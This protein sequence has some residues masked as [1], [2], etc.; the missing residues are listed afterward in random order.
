MLALS[1]SLVQTE[2]VDD[3]LKDITRFEAIADRS[4]GEI[5]PYLRNLLFKIVVET[6]RKH[7]RRPATDQVRYI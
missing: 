4:G 5:A 6:L 3:Q 2:H 7:S 1:L